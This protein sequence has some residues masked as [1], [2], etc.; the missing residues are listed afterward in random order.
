MSNEKK[1]CCNPESGEPTVNRSSTPMWIIVVTLGLLFFGG[2]YLDSHGGW[3][4]PRVYAPYTSAEK[5]DSLQPRSGEAAL[6][7]RGKF[8][9]EGVCGSCHSNDG[10][11]KPGQ[12]PPLAGSPWVIA[13]GFHRLARF[14]LQGFTGPIEING[15]Q[16]NFPAGEMAAMGAAL[17]DG[18]VAAILTYIRSAW[19]NK[20]S[21]V[22]AEDI[23]AIRNGLGTNPPKLTQ[24][25][26]MQI[27]E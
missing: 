12:F 15:Q 1:S 14:P 2:L 11:G 3:F 7:A 23:K 6:F 24:A 8:L 17:P 27:P 4:N 18:D 19:G 26:I 16:M 9:Y 21:A 20:A 13:K 5:L 22:T 25:Q 10:T